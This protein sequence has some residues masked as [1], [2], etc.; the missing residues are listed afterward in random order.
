MTIT[1]YMIEAGKTCKRLPK[2]QHVTH[3]ILG[4][5]G[6]HQEALDASSPEEFFEE[7]G[8]TFWY[9]ANLCRV[10]EIPCKAYPDDP[11]FS[12]SKIVGQLAE[13]AKK[14]MFYNKELNMEKFSRNVQSFIYYVFEDVSRENLS[15]I[16]EQNILKLRR[17]YSSGFTEVEAKAKNDKK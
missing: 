3:M 16:L 14:Y 12:Y 15:F 4:M 13:D 17:R 5:I 1:E 9:I 2:P 10:L 6:E 7:I 8:D 11:V